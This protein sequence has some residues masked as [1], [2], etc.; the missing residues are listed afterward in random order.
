MESSSSWPKPTPDVFSTPAFPVHPGQEE[1]TVIHTD[2]YVRDMVSISVGLGARR[3]IQLN[4][5]AARDLKESGY[6]VPWLRISHPRQPA[7]SGVEH[8]VCSTM[9]SGRYAYANIGVIRSSH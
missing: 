9:H 7:A 3:K 6:A 4:I 5:A 1:L 2:L 8:Y